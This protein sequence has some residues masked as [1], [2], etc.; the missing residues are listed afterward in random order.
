MRG[1]HGLVAAQGEHL[2]GVGEAVQQQ[3]CALCHVSK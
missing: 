1:Q 3:P 2:G